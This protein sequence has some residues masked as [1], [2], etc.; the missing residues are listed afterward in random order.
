M[1]ITKKMTNEVFTEMSVLRH[2]KEKIPRH[3]KITAH[4]GQP[5]VNPEGFVS[6]TDWLPSLSFA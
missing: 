2:Q 1:Q 4:T 6:A 5:A 3:E